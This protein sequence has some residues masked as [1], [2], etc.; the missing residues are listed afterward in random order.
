MECINFDRQFQLYMAEWIKQNGEKYKDDM[1]VIEDMMPQIYADYLEKPATWLD[2]K[3][4]SEYFEQFDQAQMLVQWMCCYEEKKIPVPDLLL[5]RIVSLGK[6]AEAALISVL[7][8]E[9]ANE[10]AVVTAVSLL[11]ELESTTPMQRYIDWVAQADEIGERE[12]LAAEALVNMGYAI[13]EPI[14]TALS[15]ST[16]AGKDVFADVLCNFP[17]DDRVFELLMDRFVCCE[18]R[19]ALFA[20]YLAK[21]G[22][23]RALPKLIAAAEDDQVSYLDFLELSNA[24]EALGGER[25]AEHEFSGD[26]YYDSLKMMQ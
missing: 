22:D 16:E 12:N 19:L 25:P 20:S 26:P 3:K 23:E 18:D 14:L 10:H 1:D 5:D 4:P 6:E 24:I 15:A 7:Y 8:E 2:G 21:F 13:V 17:G 9:Q 11:R